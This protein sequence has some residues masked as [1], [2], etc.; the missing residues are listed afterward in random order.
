MV[1]MPRWPPAKAISWPR[2]FDKVTAQYKAAFKSD[3]FASVR[4]KCASGGQDVNQL[5][6]D[7]AGKSA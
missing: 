1:T 5:P 4:S 2:S 7:L 6:A 3:P